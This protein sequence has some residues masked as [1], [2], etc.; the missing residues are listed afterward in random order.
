MTYWPALLDK[1]LVQS[2]VSLLN[3]KGE[4]ENS[5]NISGVTGFEE[6]LPKADEAQDQ[7]DERTNNLAN[8]SLTIA[9]TFKDICLAR[10]GDKGDTV[11]VGI[12]A[13]SPEIYQ[14]IKEKLTEYEIERMFKAFC[15]GKV[16]R[17]ELDNIHALNFLLEKSLDGGGTKSLMI[18]AQGKTFASAFLNQK[19]EVP[20]ILLEEINGR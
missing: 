13:R 14:F 17:Y 10:S 12:I 16:K 4:V 11:N 6:D 20:E 3:E 8:S 18:D 19:V 9:K 1:T 2:K 5:F 7:Q 15:K